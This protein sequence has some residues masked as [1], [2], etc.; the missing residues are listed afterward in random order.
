MTKNL[1]KYLISQA[2]VVLVWIALFFGMMVRSSVGSL[3]RPERN[4]SLAAVRSVATNEAEQIRRQLIDKYESLRFVY[5]I[6]IQLRELRAEE[7][8]F[9]RQQK[10]MLQSPADKSSDK[11]AKSRCVLKMR[12]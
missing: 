6:V 11:E 1:G 8:A 4:T 2:G 12:G 3:A 9:E 7:S 5:R 10:A